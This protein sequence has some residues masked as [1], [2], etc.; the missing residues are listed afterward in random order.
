MS[1]IISEYPI[2]LDIEASGFG[3]GS[4]P[5]EVGL[6]LGDG[7]LL[8]RLIKPLDHWT[9]W[10]ESAEQ[11]H[12]ISRRRLF[13]EGVDPRELAIELNSLLENQ[14]VY[15]DGWGVD[16]SWLALL[17]HEAG[18][19]QRFKLE[20]IYTLLS[21]EQLDDWSDHRDQVLERTGM[22]LHRAGTDALI[23]QDTYLHAV[24]PAAFEKK[25]YKTKKHNAA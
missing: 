15:T 21:E 22:V 23:V 6:A 19:I 18:V 8:A 12:G 11:V 3:S 9:H 14:M 4:Y 16:R 17:F 1:G 24:N 25:Y 20:S 2:V 10:Q 7:R 13:E 5:I